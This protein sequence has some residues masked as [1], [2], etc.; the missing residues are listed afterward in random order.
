MADRYMTQLRALT[1]NADKDEFDKI[2][3]ADLETTLDV[4]KKW[5]PL[6]VHRPGALLT[7][8]DKCVLDGAWWRFEIINQLNGYIQQRRSPKKDENATTE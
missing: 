1:C 4:L 7:D 6:P 8:E 3:L 2:K 5:L